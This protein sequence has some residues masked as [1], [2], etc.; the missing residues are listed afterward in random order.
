MKLGSGM[1]ISGDHPCGNGLHIPR[2]KMVIWEMVIICYYCFT[3]I[4]AVMHGL[5]GLGSKKI[6]VWS[7]TRPKT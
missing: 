4:N 6:L 5:H 3:N 7:R 1:V 2:I